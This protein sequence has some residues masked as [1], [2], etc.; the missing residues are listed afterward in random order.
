MAVYAWRSSAGG[1][2]A[3]EKVMMASRV[4]CVMPM[5]VMT[6]AHEMGRKSSGRASSRRVRLLRPAARLD[7]IP[8]Q[9]KR[10]VA[11]SSCMLSLA[12]GKCG[13]LAAVVDR[14]AAFAV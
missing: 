3:A 8:H 14:G 5:A 11:S 2:L 1:G 4:V 9:M 10:P 12:R 6:R 13:V 7:D